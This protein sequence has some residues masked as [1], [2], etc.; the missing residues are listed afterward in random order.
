MSSTI[1]TDE[2]VQAAERLRPGVMKPGTL[3]TYKGGGYDGCIW[4]WN[5]FL[6]G[7]DNEIFDVY[8]SGYAGVF[9][10]PRKPRTFSHDRFLDA[11]EEADSV[12]D[13][14]TDEGREEIN[15]YIACYAYRVAQKLEDLGEGYTVLLD[16]SE[17]GRYVDSTKEAAFD[18]GYDRGNGGIGVI[19]DHLVCLDCYCKLEC[20]V[21]DNRV[22]KEEE[23]E[24]I[25]GLKVCAFCIGKAERDMSDEDRKRYD[26]IE[27]EMGS[28]T[29]V[30][31]RLVAL[32]PKFE[33]KIVKQEA[34]IVE[35]LIKEKNEILER[36]L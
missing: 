10:G 8:S 28:V 32:T 29:D 18:H 33:S 27:T 2:Q 1:L 31:A 35:R 22:D 7:K 21:C 12:S 36:Y 3:V 23:L 11:V 34:E 14:N 19:N 9:G 16:C 20:D 13:L 30:A 24:T 17:C 26:E 5:T 25:G 6:V 4:E 15:E